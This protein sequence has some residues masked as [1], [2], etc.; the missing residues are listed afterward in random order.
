MDQA[1]TDIDSDFQNRARLQAAVPQ[2]VAQIGVA[3]IRAEDPFQDE[4]RLV[5][6]GFQHDT[7]DNVWVVSQFDP[8]FRFAPESFGKLRHRRVA[9]LQALQREGPLV[10]AIHA[11]I[12]FAD[13]AT[14]GS[15]HF[16]PAFEDV[17]RMK[18]GIVAHG[19]LRFDPSASAARA[20]SSRTAFS[21]LLLASAYCMLESQSGR[22]HASNRTGR[23]G[24]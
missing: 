22:S 15:H 14:N 17:A 20:A 12:Y 5:V 21:R 3:S 13:T 11:K 8:G 19:V 10:A 23:M 1:A 16:Q 18:A 24:F 6:Y 2:A 4:H 7:R 9:C